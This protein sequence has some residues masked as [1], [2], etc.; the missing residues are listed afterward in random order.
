[1]STVK[2]PHML[3]E[4]TTRASA[5]HKEKPIT[6]LVCYTADLTLDTAEGLQLKVCMQPP[7]LLQVGS[8]AKVRL[9]RDGPASHHRPDLMLRD[10]WWIL[11]IFPRGNLGEFPIL[12]TVL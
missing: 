9:E 6:L 5:F 2:C 11:V 7:P 3:R 8:E 1:M 10:H 12:G 4:A